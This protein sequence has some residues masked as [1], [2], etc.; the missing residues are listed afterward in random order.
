[1]L[2]TVLTEASEEV[3]LDEDEL[4]GD[5][6]LGGSATTAQWMAFEFGGLLE[7]LFLTLVSNLLLLPLCPLPK[8]ALL[9]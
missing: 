4:Q 9:S 7:R 1:M 6:P 5:V 8:K 2:T 3:L